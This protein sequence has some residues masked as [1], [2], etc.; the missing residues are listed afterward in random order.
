MSHKIDSIAL[1]AMAFKCF[2]LTNNIKICFRLIPPH[3]MLTI[4]DPELKTGR[5]TISQ[6][7]CQ[8]LM[9]NIFMNRTI[10]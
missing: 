3:N 7:T 4:S 8:K 2:S 10:T 5:K 1:G 9:S 6:Q